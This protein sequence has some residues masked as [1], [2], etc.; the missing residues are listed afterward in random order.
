M[1]TPIRIAALAFACLAA[2]GLSACDGGD[3]GAAQTPTG[4]PGTAS[5]APSDTVQDPST[6]DGADGRGPGAAA[7]AEFAGTWVFTPDEPHSTTELVFDDK[8]N[9][10]IAK[11]ETSIGATGKLRATGEGAYEIAMTGD[12]GST[13]T[14]TLRPGMSEGGF[15]VTLDNGSTGML[16]RKG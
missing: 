7:I 8:G 6:A 3:G 16:A 1:K 4:G 12:D 2:L 14:Y 13:W 10:T 9:V 15:R 11:S 5:T